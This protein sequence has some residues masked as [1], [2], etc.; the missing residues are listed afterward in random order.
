MALKQ[1]AMGSDMD[2][3]AVIIGTI[4]AGFVALAIFAY[5][6]DGW[7]GIKMLAIIIVVIPGIFA[8]CIGFGLLC[9]WVVG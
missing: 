9:G 2:A 6:L 3:P 8:L 1:G 7:K 5:A 4:F